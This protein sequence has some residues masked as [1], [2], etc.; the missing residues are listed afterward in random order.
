M[1]QDSGLDAWEQFQ[2]AED[3]R[4]EQLAGL[5]RDSL[6]NSE[7]ALKAFRAINEQIDREIDAA[8]RLIVGEEPDAADQMQ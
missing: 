4:F 1:S 8:Y 7:E 2:K 5:G 6:T 3:E